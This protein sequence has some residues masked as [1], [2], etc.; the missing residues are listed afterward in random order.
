MKLLIATHNRGKLREFAELLKGLPYELVTLDEVGIHNDVE[1]TGAT[2][3]ENAQLKAEA[4][5]RASGLLTLA[6]DS[7]LE[8]DALGG[9]PGVRSKRY[10]GENKTDAERNEYLLERLRA[11]PSDRRTARFHAVIAIAD[12]QG[13][14]WSSE[15]TCEG[16]IAYD[17]R[18][19]NGFGYD[20]V[21][22]SREYGVRTAELAPEVKNRI[23]HRGRASVGARRILKEIANDHHSGV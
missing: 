8:V 15:G 1:E 19:T 13:R 7:G 6:E 3:A 11:V 17:E 2:F 18:G 14:F 12:P 21:F 16:S 10:A 4:Y 23:S 5:A 22:I 20:P 9:E